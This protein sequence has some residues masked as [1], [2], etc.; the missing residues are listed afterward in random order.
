[1]TFVS[2]AN[3]FNRDKELDVP[4]PFLFE[5]H[6]L[7]VA[8]FDEAEEVALLFGTYSVALYSYEKL[9]SNLTMQRHVRSE[10]FALILSS[11][12]VGS[13]WDHLV[14]IAG[15]MDGEILVTVPSTG[16]SIRAKFEGHRVGLEIYDDNS[17]S[18]RTV[19]LRE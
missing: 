5:D 16:P 18:S 17:E 12:L 11:I 4:T 7:D 10:R 13:S 9:S 6:P 1:M 14:V 3:L 8:V 15:T 19:Q 2:D